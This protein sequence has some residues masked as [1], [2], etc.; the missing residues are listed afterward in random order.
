[1]YTK[2]AITAV[3]VLSVTKA[4]DALFGGCFTLLFAV[5]PACGEPCFAMLEQVIKRPGLSPTGHD[6]IVICVILMWWP[7]YFGAYSPLP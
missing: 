6:I 5:A 3:N 7:F 2:L 1:M 4:S